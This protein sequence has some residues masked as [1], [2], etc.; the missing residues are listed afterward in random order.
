MVNLETVVNLGLLDRLDFLVKQV[1]VGNPGQ[2][3][4]VAHVVNQANLDQPVQAAQLDLQDQEA[5]QV[6]KANEA[7]QV[8]VVKPVPQEHQVRCTKVAV[9]DCQVGRCRM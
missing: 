5:I 6:L 2:L 7:N 9:H 4:Q 8:Y 1:N 3:D